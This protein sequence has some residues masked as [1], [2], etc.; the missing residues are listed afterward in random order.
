MYN[1]YYSIEKVSENKFAIM[2]N[3]AYFEENG[4]RWEARGYIRDYCDDY[5]FFNTNEDAYNYLKNM[6]G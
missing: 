3:H 5:L 6:E 1:V 2:K 4:I